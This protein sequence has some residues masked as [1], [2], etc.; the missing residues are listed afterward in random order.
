MSRQ[1]QTMLP[2]GTGFRLRE[3]LGNKSFLK[4]GRLKNTKIRIRM[5]IRAVGGKKKRG[6]RGAP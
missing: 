4:M 3:K 1:A 6:A 2:A 5:R